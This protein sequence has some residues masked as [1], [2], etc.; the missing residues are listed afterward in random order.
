MGTTIVDNS[1][2]YVGGELLSKLDIPILVPAAQ[3][4]DRI[5]E[6]HIKILHIAI[7]AVERELFPE[8]YTG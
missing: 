5:Q 6:L 2:S 4:S 7:E 3:T 1:D 8:N